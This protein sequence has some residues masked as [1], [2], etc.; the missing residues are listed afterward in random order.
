MDLIIL[1]LLKSNPCLSGSKYFS[2]HYYD[3]FLWQ[4]PAGFITKLKLPSWQAAVLAT[5]A[6]KLPV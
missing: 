2:S 5:E 1:V 6:R 3:Q 4:E